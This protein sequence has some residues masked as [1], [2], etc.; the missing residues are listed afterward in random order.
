[1]IKLSPRMKAIADQISPGQS[2]ADIGTDH[3]YVP[4]YLFQ[5]KLS[6]KIILTD[7]KEGP[8]KKAIAHLDSV[9]LYDHLNDIR[10][11]SGISVLEASEVDTV[12]I[13]GMGGLLIVE[14]L[15]ADINKSK[16]FLR[17]V[18]QPR[19]ASSDLRKW[20]SSTGFSI[21][22]EHLAKEGK[23]ICEI[24]TATPSEFCLEGEI[25]LEE[26]DFEVPPLLTESNDPLLKT[27][28]SDKIS[29]TQ[30]I[31]NALEYEK[32]SDSKDR[33]INLKNKIKTLT[34]RKEAL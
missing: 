25:F 21:I 9:G 2:V 30:T 32:A 33:V 3:A 24:I 6:S 11:G 4:I 22:G 27:F 28:L 10:R 5:N 12:V 13:A 1:M 29:K 14:M 31:I 18:L 23:R 8:L 19:T 7:I 17:F 16:T 26:I 34:E 20:L 15:A